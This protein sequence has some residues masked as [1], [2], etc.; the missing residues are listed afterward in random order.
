MK[1]TKRRFPPD[2]APKAIISLREF[3]P[4]RIHLLA[5]RIATPAAVD[6][7]DSIV[8]R[9]RDWRVILQL[10]TRGPL[11]N[12]EIASVVGL[13]TATI[14]RVAQNLTDLGLVTA[15]TSSS[16]RRKQIISLTT[17]GAE[18]HDLIAP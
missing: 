9:A 1:S 16:D 14:T 7:G 17:R 3:L 2:V 10:A 6:V 4:Y 18:V 12:A 8:I 15:R 5:A 13:D 11:T